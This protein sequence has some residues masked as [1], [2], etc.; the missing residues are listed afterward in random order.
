MEGAHLGKAG[1]LDIIELDRASYY[2]AQVK[3]AGRA[4]A[5]HPAENKMDFVLAGTQTD[6]VMETF[7]GGRDRLITVHLCTDECGQLETGLTEKDVGKEKMKKKKKERSLEKGQKTAR[8]VFSNTCLD[9]NVSRRKRLIKKARKLRQKSEKK[10]GPISSG[11][12][13]SSAATSTEEEGTEDEG[14]LF[15]ET[16]HER[17]PGAL[18]LQAIENMREHLMSVRGDLYSSSKE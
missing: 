17:F 2:Q 13:D 1:E 15:E 14:P 9:P 4:R 11:E 10:R 6:R 16:R 3:V 18:T 5:F 7:G 12:E 8:A